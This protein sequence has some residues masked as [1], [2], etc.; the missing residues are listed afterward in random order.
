[1]QPSKAGWAQGAQ[2]V[3]HLNQE[4]RR[5]LA[6]QAAQPTQVRRI[7]IHG[8]H[9]FRGQ[10]D[11]IMC[12]ARADGTEH[13]FGRFDGVV[14]E[15]RDI[16]ARGAR[17]ALQGIVRELVEHDMVVAGHQPAHGAECRAPAGGK[18]EHARTL[19]KLA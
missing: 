1:M 13:L 5:V 9:A 11:G 3:C 18:E 4:R 8:K 14:V 2:V 17:P 19:E 15:E 12:V 6:A 10:Q 16:F 7:R